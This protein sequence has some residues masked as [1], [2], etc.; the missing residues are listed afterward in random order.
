MALTGN[1]PPLE[2]ILLIQLADL[3]RDGGSF[4]ST[5]TL[6]QS[7]WTDHD[8]YQRNPAI[9]RPSLVLVCGDIVYGVSGK[10]SDPDASLKRQYQEAS[11]TLIA[12]ADYLFDGDRTK[13][14][15]VPGNHDINMAYV[16]QALTEVPWP[17][18][19]Q[20]REMLASQLM[21]RNSL[22]RLDVKTLTLYRIADPGLYERR[23]EHFANFFNDFYQ[24]AHTFN[25]NPADQ[26]NVHD[27]PELGI[28]LIGFS[29][30][31]GNDIYNRAGAIH[32][33][34]LSKASGAVRD[35]AKQGRLI[36]A[37][38]HHN[39]H[40]GPALNDYMDQDVLQSIMAAQCSLGFHGHQHRPE[41]LQQKYSGGAPTT[42]SVISAGTLCGG[43]S[44]LPMGRMRGYNLVVLDLATKKGTVHVRH[45]TNERLEAPTWGECFIPEFQGSSKQFDFT[46]PGTPDANEYVLAQKIDTLRHEGRTQAAW[47]ILQNHLRTPLLRRLATEVLQDLED[48]PLIIQHLAPPSTS[49]EFILL[50]EAYKETEKWLELRGLIESSYAKSS[51][52]VGVRQKIQD[53]ESTLRRKNS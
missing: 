43:A 4:I 13:L 28:C 42:L 48:W 39:T 52:D 33:D 18:N 1:T 44:S 10:E 16:R 53:C 9:P 5:E 12:I 37:V 20:K 3:H 45:M 17:K 29:S 2:P 7:L 31:Y 40:G 38:W 46:M 24:G 19:R 25:L 50:C 15:I 34:A 22:F 47:D 23:L 35:L 26:F 14:V 21:A 8:Q 6:L 30:C 11:E 41:Y 36:G 49:A 32:P 27:F 51:V